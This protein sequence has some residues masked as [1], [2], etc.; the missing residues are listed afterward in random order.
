MND[1]AILIDCWETWLS[2]FKIPFDYDY[3]LFN[4]IK[5][6]VE[7]NDNIK[8][9]ILATYD[10]ID[11]SNTIWHANSLKL[12]GEEL[13]NN[14]NILAN[15]DPKSFQRTDKIILNWS[16]KKQQIAM[17]YPWEFEMF[18][19]NNQIDNIYMCGGAMDIC[20]RVRPLGYESLFNI[21]Q[22][23][24]LNT[25]ILLKE[26]CVNDSKGKIFKL[27]D[28]P[29]WSSTGVEGIFKLTALSSIG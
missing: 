1:I 29:G 18:I 9:I 27:E 26:D 22:K 14:K 8:T 16:S 13:Y 20:V 25:H 17:H 4:K 23:Y 15:V 10:S 6:F 24:N 11:E 12:L 19:K 5:K 21:I 3:I 28:Y 7:S 2:K